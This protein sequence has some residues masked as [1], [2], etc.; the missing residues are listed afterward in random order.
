MRMKYAIYDDVFWLGI[1]YAMIE[2]L[3]A[4]KHIEHIILYFL[5]T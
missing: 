2:L 3:C 4:D 5:G 1:M